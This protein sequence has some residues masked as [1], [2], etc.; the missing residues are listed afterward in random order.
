[1]LR[2]SGSVLVPD[3][4]PPGWRQADRSSHHRIIS[5]GVSTRDASPP[6]QMADIVHPPFPAFPDTP[7]LPSILPV[8]CL[9]PACPARPACCQTG[10]IALCPFFLLAPS[11]GL[12]LQLLLPCGGR[13]HLSVSVPSRRALKPLPAPT[14]ALRPSPSSPPRPSLEGRQPALLPRHR[15]KQDTQAPLEFLS[16]RPLQPWDA[17]TIDLAVSSAAREPQSPDPCFAVAISVPPPAT[18]YYRAIDPSRRSFVPP[19]GTW[20]FQ[21]F[22][23]ASSV[24]PPSPVLASL[25]FCRGRRSNRQLRSL[26]PH[27][28]W[29][30]ST[31]HTDPDVRAHRPFEEISWRPLVSLAA[32]PASPRY[33][34]GWTASR[35]ACFVCCR[36][37]LQ[38]GE[39]R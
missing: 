29:S 14:R 22:L 37:P 39:I 5:A 15:G 38:S 32:F 4:A 34:S 3:A 26:D 19:S 16:R 31:R 7:L 17:R 21:V 2:S 13:S 36:G 33:C 9:C 24:S 30:R 23:K 1:M 35:M 12:R 11:P 10:R 8:G 25:T 6:V 18:A 20:S 28:A 27:P